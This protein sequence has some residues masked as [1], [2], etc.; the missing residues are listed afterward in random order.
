MG[1]TRTP[2]SS[3]IRASAF[4]FRAAMA[5]STFT[6]APCRRGAMFSTKGVCSLSFTSERPNSHMSSL[7]KLS[8]TISLPRNSMPMS[9]R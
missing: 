4:S 3:A 7:Q 1:C 2:R 9:P 8:L 5:D 6:V